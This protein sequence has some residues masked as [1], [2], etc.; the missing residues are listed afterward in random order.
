MTPAMLAKEKYNFKN[1]LIEIC[2]MVPDLP[3]FAQVVSDS[4]EEILNE[5]RALTSVS[6]NITVKVITNEK[7]INGL[8]L[9]KAEGIPACATCIH[10]VIEAI[11][12]GVEHAAV[13]VG[14]LRT[15]SEQSVDGLL[16]NIVKVY[17][18]SGL[19]TKEMTAVRSINQLVNGLI[20][21]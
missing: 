4:P 19:E 20:Y 1:A 5:G 21:N 17:R 12:V 10:C 9:L 2:R 6:D 3:V 11:S 13:F 18:K 16:R 8:K 15:V 7:G 14:R